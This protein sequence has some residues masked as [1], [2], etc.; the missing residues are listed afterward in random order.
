[1]KFIL[2]FGGRDVTGFKLSCHSIPMFH[3]MGM[4]LTHW[5]VGDAGYRS[6]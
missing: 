4:M 6:G 3:G 1:M 2:G 5:T